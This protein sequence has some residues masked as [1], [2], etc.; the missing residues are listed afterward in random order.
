MLKVGLTGGIGSGKTT[1]LSLFNS[2]G[3]PIYQS[4]ERA[5]WL[6]NNHSEIINSLTSLF[7]DKIYIDKK[8]NAAYLS[9]IVFKD[10]EKLGQLNSV[11]HPKVAEDFIFW[12]S[13][14]DASYVVKEAAILIETGAYKQ[15]DK[16]IRLDKISKALTK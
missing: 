16:I 12:C 6:I 11:V 10:P 14:Q 13:K 4:D 7:G 1:V 9:N 3:V 5:K 15:L 2:L 8:I